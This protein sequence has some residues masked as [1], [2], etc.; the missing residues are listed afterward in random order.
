MGVLLLVSYRQ[1]QFKRN[2]I[3][4]FLYMILGLVFI[5]S[6]LKLYLQFAPEPSFSLIQSMTH[7]GPFAQKN[8]F[9]T[10][11]V[12]GLIISFVL[13]IIDETISSVG[14]K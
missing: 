5:Q 7:F 8:I 3:H 6:L 4:D 2:D 10:Y 11:L 14:W 1:F 13:L 12:T 9:A